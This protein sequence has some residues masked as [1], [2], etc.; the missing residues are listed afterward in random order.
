M[1]AVS[2]GRTPVACSA[3]GNAQVSDQSDNLL[4]VTVR[5]DVMVFVVFVCTVRRA[6][7]A[8]VL[9]L[10]TVRR[11]GVLDWALRRAA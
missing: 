10:A 4:V 1:H 7:C 9:L 11:D 5:S 3:W 2:E 8:G 6:P